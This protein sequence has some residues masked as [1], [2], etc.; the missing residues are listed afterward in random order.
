[1][2]IQRI[3]KISELFSDLLRSTITFR[4]CVFGFVLFC[5]VLFRFHFCDVDVYD[6]W[7]LIF[8]QIRIEIP[9]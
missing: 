3:M 2:F 9:I 4:M 8:M 6:K 5:F 1:M 7:F